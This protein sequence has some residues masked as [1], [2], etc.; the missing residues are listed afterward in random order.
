MAPFWVALALGLQMSSSFGVPQ[1]QASE[2]TLPDRATLI[3]NEYGISTTTLANLVWS[4]SRWDPNATS[5]TGDYGL[6][7]INLASHPSITK[8]QALDPIFALDYAA[9]SIASSTQDQF[10]SCNCYAY[11]RTK[12]HLPKMADITPNSP[13]TV[14]GLAI[15]NYHGIKHIAYIKSVEGDGFWVQES[16]YQPCLVAP[17]Y[18]KWTDKAIVGYWATSSM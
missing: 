2:L 13:P 6:V 14:G 10:T 9:Q 4:E 7:Q 11:A 15:F 1:A 18:V 8:D 3:A 16:N 12:L 5:T 17:R